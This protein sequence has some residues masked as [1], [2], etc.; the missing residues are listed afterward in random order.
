MANYANQKRIELD[1]NI[2]VVFHQKNSPTE[3]YYPPIEYCYIDKAAQLLNGNA[4]KL[5]LYLIRWHNQGWV[6]FS[7]AAVEEAMG[8]KKS[9]VSDARKELVTKGFLY[10]DKEHSNKLYFTPI[11]KLFV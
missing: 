4:F 11:S 7:P 6:N 10:E 8:M 5:W 2:K 9:S 1:D 3:G